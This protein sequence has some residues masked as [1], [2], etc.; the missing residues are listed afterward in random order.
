MNIP[1]ILHFVKKEDKNLFFLFV[2]IFLL[3]IIVVSNE[4]ESL[5]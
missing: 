1:K 5:M 2:F 3:H 4:Y